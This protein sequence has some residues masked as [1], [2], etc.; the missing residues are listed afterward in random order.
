M[1]VMDG[2]E[3]T[4]HIRALDSTKKAIPIIALTASIQPNERQ[5]YLDAGVSAI[6]G[7]P[8]SLRELREAVQLWGLPSS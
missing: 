2:L 7:K 8:F 1:P 4:R 3:T 6:I 5:R